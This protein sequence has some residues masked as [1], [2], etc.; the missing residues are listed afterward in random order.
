MHLY[1]ISRYFTPVDGEV[2]VFEA[3]VPEG[4]LFVLGDNRQNSKDSRDL[5]FIDER[6]V[7]GE[8]IY[9]LLPLSAMGDP[10]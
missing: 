6:H 1:S 8:V 7:I 4:H 5:G 9:R 3:T 10:T 2:G